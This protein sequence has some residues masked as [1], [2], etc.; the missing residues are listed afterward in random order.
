MCEWEGK[1]VTQLLIVVIV[2]LFSSWQI[3]IQVQ[4]YD[5]M[6]GPVVDSLKYLTPL[7]YDV[8]G[9]CIVEV[10]SDNKERVANDGKWMY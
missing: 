10:L 4:L 2:S 5:N 9:Y 7:S 6:I 1:I 3:L 8:L